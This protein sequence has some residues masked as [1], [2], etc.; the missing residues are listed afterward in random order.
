[1]ND[2]NPPVSSV[3]T[4]PSSVT[5]FAEMLGELN[6]GVF[7]Q[8]AGRALSDVALGTVAN[9]DGK[10]KGKVNISFEFSRI[11]ESSQVEIKHTLSY[12]KP[13]SRGK[14]SEDATTTT[15]MHV[16]RGGRLTITP[17]S[18]GKLD[19]EQSQGR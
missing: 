19:F 17:E 18:Q 5:D 11:G 8:Q 3:T 10:K 12:V 2:N 1:M 7:L 9:G 16:G 6:G 4:L 15:P 13:T 14:S